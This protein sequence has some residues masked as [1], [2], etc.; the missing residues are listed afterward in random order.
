MVS[1]IKA[2]KKI[3]Y[4]KK[5]SLYL[6]Y[7]F[8]Q[9]L[10]IKNFTFSKSK[11]FLNLIVSLFLNSIF[12]D[13]KVSSFTLFIRFFLVKFSTNS[14]KSESFLSDYSSFLFTQKNKPFNFTSSKTSFRFYNQTST[15]IQ[16]NNL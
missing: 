13:S 9:I 15:L 3:Y 6:L 4:F 12:K 7:Y 10:Y 5:F 8:C 1:N 14:F 11:K 16:N 2:L